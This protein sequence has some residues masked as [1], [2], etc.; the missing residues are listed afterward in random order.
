MAPLFKSGRDLLEQGLDLARRR[1]FARA[2][3][4]FVDAAARLA[5][6]SG[7]VEA[8]L[9]RAYAD[10]MGFAVRAPDPTAERALA[11]FLRTRLGSMELRP[12]LR[13]IS[14]GALATQLD[15]DARDR[16]LTAQTDPVA[17]DPAAYAQALQA[18]AGGYA[19][20]TGQVLFLPELIQQRTIAA[21]SRVPVLM[22]TAFETLGLAAQKADP[23]AAAERF[24]TAQQYWVQAGEGRRAEAAGHLIET[25]SLR[26]RCWF[27]GRAGAG[28]G[29]QFVSMPVDVALAGLKDPSDS[30]LPAV[31]PTGHHLYVCIGCHSAVR[32]LAERIAD[33]RAAAVA[34][35]LRAE[36]R[37]MERRLRPGSGA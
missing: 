16:E 30:P 26:A 11:E 8:D 10:L 5:K 22:A 15:L 12:G 23:I 9:A 3:E 6:E 19:G 17:T 20:I 18:L 2:R 25:L 31:D 27:C 24:Q 13:P 36:M 37:A 35:Q 29:V 7:T 21:E 1:D 34:E 32:G 14:G 33:R 28:H 4:K